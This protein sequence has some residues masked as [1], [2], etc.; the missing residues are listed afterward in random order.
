MLDFDAGERVGAGLNGNAGEITG[1]EGR[2]GV[3][4]LM[5]TGHC[6]AHLHAAD[7]ELRSATLDWLKS[8]HPVIAAIVAEACDA[9]RRHL[10]Q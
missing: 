4:G 10:S 8:L 2:G 9:G 6:E 1:R 7:R 5:A 3:E